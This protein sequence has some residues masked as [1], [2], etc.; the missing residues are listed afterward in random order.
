MF[1]L[2]KSSHRICTTWRR[3]ESNPQERLSDWVYKKP[4]LWTSEWATGKENEKGICDAIITNLHKS[5]LSYGKGFW[6]VRSMLING[7]GMCG[8]WYQMFQHMAHCQ[9]V[10]IHRRCFFV[11]LRELPHESGESEINWRAINIKSPGLNLDEISEDL[12]SERTFRD[13]DSEYPIRS[14][15]LISERRERRWIFLG[16]GDGHC[17]NLLPYQG[18]LYLY[19]ACFGT[20]PFDIEPFGGAEAPLPPSNFVILG[21]AEL[22][23][24]K[25]VY[26]DGAVD[27]MMGSLIGPDGVF[28]GDIPGITVRTEVIPEIWFHPQN[29]YTDGITFKWVP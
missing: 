20:G 19:D 4:M 26:L 1:G 28:Y 25:R 6:S 13:D 29:G 7:G 14:T 10:F 22:S 11:D 27:Y 23:S 9:G 18:K 12:A 24:F 15:T 21:G 17:I 3:L 8:G 5:G 16:P 2:G